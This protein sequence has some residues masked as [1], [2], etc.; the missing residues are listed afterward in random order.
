VL[1]QIIL[2]MS[3]FHPIAV[4]EIFSMV[5]CI[6]AYR[7]L[8]SR[9]LELVVDMLAGRFADSRI[10][11]LNPRI[12]YDRVK[13]MIQA[14][15]GA[16]MLL[17][18]SGGV[19]PDRGF[20]TLR[21]VDS[22]AKIG[23]L[24]EEFVWERSLGE[25]F[26]FGN[27][28]WR[29][30]RITPNEVEVLPADSSNTVVPFW[31][32]DDIYR[33]AEYCRR[34]GEFLEDVEQELAARLG[35]GNPPEALLQKL[36]YRYS[37]TP[38]AAE[39][40]YDYLHRQRE[41]TG[42]PLPHRRH[43]VIERFADPVN[44]RDMQ[45][46][47]LHTMRG[48]AVNKPFALAIA[49]AWRLQ[50]GFPLEVFANN[51]AILCNLP[52]EF[53][54]DSLLQ[55]VHEERIPQLLRDSIEGGPLFGARFRENAQRSLLLPRRSFTQRTPLWL[56]RMRSKKLLEAISREEDFPITLETWR[57][58]LQSV[59]D[60]PALYEL[61]ADIRS[62][63][64]AVSEVAVSSPSPFVS[65]IIWRQT[66]YQIYLD[67][68]AAA[69]LRT[70]M[71][72]DLLREILESPH[73]RP[74]IPAELSAAFQQ[75]LQ[76]IQPGYAPDSAADLIAWVEE[77][78]F[79]P[80]PEWK[81]L[82]T[83]VRTDN[84]EAGEL[85]LSQAAERL[86]FLSDGVLAQER[87]TFISSAL[88][89]D[90]D[91]DTSAPAEESRETAFRF[92][93]QWLR[94]YAPL[95]VSK[96][97]AVLPAPPA[98]L[99]IILED[100]SAA[101]A[102]IIDRFTPGTVEDEVCERENL[103]RLLRIRRAQSRPD[104]Q[105]MPA[106]RLQLFLAALQGAVHPGSSPGEMEKRLELL[107]GYPARAELWESEIL[108]SR[109]NPYFGAWLDTALRQS[110]LVWFG[111]GKRMVAF[112]FESDLELF[113]VVDNDDT[114][115]D[116]STTSDSAVSRI[117]RL[118]SSGRKYTFLDLSSEAG[119]TTESTAAALWELV[120]RGLAHNDGMD[121]LRQGIK[122]KFRPD[123]VRE[124]ADSVIPGAQTDTAGVS[125]QPGH[126]GH[127]GRANPS[128][129]ARSRRVGTRGGFNRWQAT[130]PM[131]GVWSMPSWP[132]Y[133]PDP[134]EENDLVKD[135][136]RV[137]FARYGILCRELLKNEISALQWRE[138]ARTLRLM[139]L[140]GETYGG[141]FIQGLRGMQ[142]ISPAALRVLNSNL[143]DDAVYWLNAT[144]PASLCGMNFESGKGW[145]PSR[146]PS[147][148]LV[149]HGEQLVIISRRYGRELN[150][151]APSDAPRFQEYLG[152]FG[153]LL[154]RE[155][156]PRTRI[157]VELIN[158]LPAN[159]SEY[160]PQL[161]AYGFVND[162]LSLSLWKRF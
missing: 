14:R 117:M 121:A 91:G 97:A 27:R 162:G 39:E 29:I 78:L 122:H 30:T 96:V 132:D 67:D 143:P 126:S 116:A 42:C 153:M 86:V 160:A 119:C 159:E 104:I 12:T 140:S 105:P 98:F 149:F 109:L 51:D 38:R 45:Q 21:R 137:L 115:A 46:V 155:Q 50:Y 123:P 152:V 124:I 5:R 145:L 100:L 22:G 28:A 83:A 156:M 35:S 11:E 157:R 4:D 57:E 13:G 47:V 114:P 40:L 106:S 73:L 36:Q 53:Q 92:L 24:D 37:M 61:L 79:I 17:Y 158:N 110:E 71:G 77:R 125:G 60:L 80:L 33:P 26:P 148:H 138:I 69:N 112:A 3:L 74:E 151:S 7:E 9:E 66:N 23:E 95:P 43:I 118:L 82:C 93:S 81:A 2:S 88:G 49:A 147:T 32:A 18:M 130:R 108:P 52:H 113:P 10:R 128:R 54:V 131:N 139:E 41:H 15:K 63:E 6:Y 58:C 62:G 56:T 141:S 76:R 150:I 84:P 146:V 16:A 65:S 1:A 64:I 94:Y 31:R 20:Y 25:A 107:F 70:A 75:K 85:I 90:A 142:F 161:R 87:A 8:T 136:I 59:F 72:D 34:L 144:D 103:D 134:L 154:A 55:L 68:S 120:W 19:I 111:C 127:P 99:Q 129:P 102:I 89:W 48:G 101:G 135:R 133:Q 44:A